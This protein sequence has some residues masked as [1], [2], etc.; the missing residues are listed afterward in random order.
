[1]VLGTNPLMADWDVNNRYKTTDA[2]RTNIMGKTLF[3]SMAR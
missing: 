1:M 3:D 2:T